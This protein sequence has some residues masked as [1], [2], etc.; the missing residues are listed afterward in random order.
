MVFKP[1]VCVFITTSVLTPYS[2]VFVIYNAI[3]SVLELQVITDVALIFRVSP[4][5]EARLG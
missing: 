4:G 1:F 5:R 2:V 3:Y